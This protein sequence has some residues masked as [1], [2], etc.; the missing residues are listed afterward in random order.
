[1]KELARLWSRAH[2]VFV[3]SS[4]TR[5]RSPKARLSLTLCV[6]ALVHLSLVL[7]VVGASTTQ[8]PY[9]HS[10]AVFRA[11][12]VE[13]GT[14]PDAARPQSDSTAA[15][16]EG[17]GRSTADD[18]R[19]GAEASAPPPRATAASERAPE[20]TASVTRRA[21]QRAAGA[22]AKRAERAIA[23]AP[24]STASS[25]SRVAEDAG[26]FGA[27]GLPPG[28]QYFAKAFA[29]ALPVVLSD[30][31]WLALPLGPAGAA[32]IDVSIDAAGRISD[33]ELD[34]RAN[35]PEILKRAIDRVFVLLNAGSFSLDGQRVK[36][37]I[38]RLSLT[39]ELSQ[40]SA[41]PNEGADP[42]L[43]NEKGHLL[44]APGRA[45]SAHLTF[46]SGRRVQVAIRMRELDEP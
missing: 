7:S 11:N 23:A 10:P 46:N 24:P 19:E 33:V 8:A 43:M 25:A 3:R 31:A 30:T 36:M 6:S 40:R 41:N 35:T 22:L 45:G 9:S 27:V 28:T 29:R 42:K 44:P 21:N 32:S 2:T 20:V 38:Q 17:S 16:A 37:G 34:P 26:S 39:V 14:V 15:A 12:T 13:V 18:E 1:M 5:S 4:Q